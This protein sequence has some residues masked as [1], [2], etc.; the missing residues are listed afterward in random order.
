MIYF[1]DDF[2]FR[3]NNFITI[4]NFFKNYDIK[5]DY[6][7]YHTDLKKEIVVSSENVN[8][9]IET[10]YSEKYMGINLYNTYIYELLFICSLVH[11]WENYNI[12]SDSKELCLF[13]YDNFKK[14]LLSCRKKS[15]FFIKY[16][17]KV[18]KNESINVGISFGGNLIYTNCYAKVLALKHIPHFCVEHFFTGNDFYFEQ[19]YEPLPNNSILQNE[20]FCNIK[21][22]LVQDKSKKFIKLANEKNKNVKQPKYFSPS[23]H[24]YI[25]II[26]QVRNDFSILSKN[27]IFKNSIKFYLDI[28]KKILNNTNYNIIIK[29]HPYEIKK[30]IENHLTTFYILNRELL[31]IPLAKDRVRVVDNFSINSLIDNA[32]MVITLNSQS[33]LQAVERFKPVVCFGEAFYGHKGFTFDYINI[34]D[35]IKNIDKINF[36]LDNYSRY[37]NFMDVSF[38]HLIGIGEEDKLKIIFESAVNIEKIKSIST[39]NIPVKKIK[40]KV[41]SIS[42][43]TIHHTLRSQQQSNIFSWRKTK[44]L[45]RS[46]LKFIKDSKAFSMLSKFINVV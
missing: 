44:K 33:G 37:L 5:Y 22:E 46:P 24:G 2:N 19:R 34:D 8:I 31:S 26:A 30:V 16:W 4:Y 28:I 36:T 35:F 20:R 14:E 42:H 27:N 25:L 23:D 21:S 13:L 32:S 39:N 6:D 11:G 45:F 29:T 38:E 40:S 15:I 3:K 7:K 9:D 43:A 10:I 41:C 1:S 12:P 18:I 17:N